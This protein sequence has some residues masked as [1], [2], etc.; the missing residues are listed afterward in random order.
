MAGGSDDGPP[1]AVVGLGRHL[2]HD[3]ISRLPF[4]KPLIRVI[5]ALP[6]SNRLAS[7]LSEFS[8][9]G[10]GT[11]TALSDLRL[12]ALALVLPTGGELTLD[13]FGKVVGEFI[14]R[15]G[16]RFLALAQ[17]GH[18]RAAVAEACLALPEDSVFFPAARVA[19]THKKIGQVLDELRGRGVG[20]D[21][22]Q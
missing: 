7:I 21:E 15:A 9:G 5:A 10:A 11:V 14:T 17:S 22:L 18:V 19:G 13:P 12:R 2:R 4:M 8:K 6:G 16:G 1:F 3:T 20:A